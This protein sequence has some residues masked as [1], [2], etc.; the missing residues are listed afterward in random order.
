MKKKLKRIAALVLGVAV[1]VGG[2]HCDYQFSQRVEALADTTVSGDTHGM[3]HVDGDKLYDENGKEYVIKSMGMGN[4]VWDNPTKP[5]KSYATEES[6]KELSELGFNGVRYYINVNLFED[7]DNNYNYKED[8]FEWLSQNIA[9]ADKYDMKV[10]INM[11]VPAGGFMNT[12]SAYLWNPQAD[13]MKRC[14]ELWKEI[15]RRY[16][17]NKAV[18][19]YGLLNEPF[20]LKGYNDTKYEDSYCLDQYY[21]YIEELKDAIRSQG[22]NHILFVERPYGTVYYSDTSGKFTSTASYVWGDTGSFRIIN[23]SNT[24][25]EFHYYEPGALTHTG[26]D[27]GSYE[28]DYVYTDATAIPRGGKVEKKDYYD[29]ATTYD[30]SS[31]SWQN[32]ET[33]LCKNEGNFNYGYWTL[34]T[35][36]HG[37]NG[38]ILVD[39]VVVSEYDENGKYVRDV[40]VYH[41]S[42]PKAGF[43]GW[44]IDK[45]GGSHGY[46]AA[47]G[48]FQNGCIKISGLKNGAYRLYKSD[49]INFVMKTGYSYKVSAYVKFID[50]DNTAT[51][52]PGIQAKKAERLYPLNK[53]YLDYYLS[54]FRQFGID[55]NVPM[56]VGE[57]GASCTTINSEN[58]AIQWVSDMLDLF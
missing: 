16:K 49:M 51:V 18:L 11:H 5:V 39:D 37:E 54:I 17:D 34:R 52:N 14:K 22:D 46:D 50:C 53:D 56:Y 38:S 41:F 33:G 2:S 6:Y 44:D 42:N 29:V 40:N 47:E 1:A 13:N 23:D 30:P 21:D 4:K 43:S 31:D 32:I 55:N 48:H 10:L 24:V 57:V 9:W 25:Y 45:T 58:N 12:S 28:P 26:L 3:I 35:A 7:K 8:G 27:Y 20:M 19:G 15:S 36:G